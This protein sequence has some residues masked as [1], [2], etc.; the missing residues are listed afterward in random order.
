MLCF[1]GVMLAICV[2]FMA[3]AHDM[4]SAADM[5]GW[6]DGFDSEMP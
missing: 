5:L 3:T 2:F 6:D 1:L 4:F